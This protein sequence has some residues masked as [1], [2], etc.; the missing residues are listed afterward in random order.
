MWIRE[1]LQEFEINFIQT[2]DDFRCLGTIY[3]Y[4]LKYLAPLYIM[5]IS[6]VKL[7]KKPKIKKMA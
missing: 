6:E 3:P 4:I 5:I 1:F 2:I 7:W